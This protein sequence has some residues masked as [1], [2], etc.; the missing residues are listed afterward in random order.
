MLVRSGPTGSRIVAGTVALL[1]LAACS[2]QEWTAFVY[3][4][5]GDIPRADQV[6]NFTIGKFQTFEECQAA[7]IGRVRHIAATTGRQGD[8]QCGLGCS[9]REEYGGLLIC[10]E[11]R[12]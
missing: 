4:D 5:A 12:K 10:K 6:Q 2:R 3:P 9:H 7:A 11:K 1:V 8:F